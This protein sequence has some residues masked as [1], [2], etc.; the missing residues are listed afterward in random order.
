MAGEE[1]VRPG[2]P[3]SVHTVFLSS[4]VHTVFL[5]CCTVI[6]TLKPCMPWSAGEP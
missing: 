5:G 3:S 6:T 2:Y 1:G 4:S